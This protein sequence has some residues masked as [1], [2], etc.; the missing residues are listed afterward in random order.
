MHRNLV[1]AGD[2]ATAADNAWR[3]ATL[4][5][6][7]LR[8]RLD[9]G[10]LLAAPP[11]P[12][13]SPSPDN[14]PNLPAQIGALLCRFNA[15]LRAGLAGRNGDGAPLGEQEL[16]AAEAG[17]L[18]LDTLATGSLDWLTGR[19]AAAGAA[20]HQEMLL[21]HFWCGRALTRNL[22]R[23]QDL[24]D[25]LDLAPER[26]SALQQEAARLRQAGAS[27]RL[28]QLEVIQALILPALARRETPGFAWPRP[29]RPP[30]LPGLLER[31]LRYA[32]RASRQLARDLARLRRAYRQGLEHKQRLLGRLTVMA[33][34]LYAMSAVLLYAA[35]RQG[36]SGC[37]PLADLFCRQARRRVATWRRALYHNDDQ[38]AYD[39]ALDVLAGHYPWLEPFSSRRQVTSR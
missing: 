38:F 22:A 13:C 20:H 23:L 17:E 34:E 14:S 7:L 31:H 3:T 15:A 16:I 27:G 12:A 10:R 4:V 6:D 21:A 29:L 36:P 25:A 39:R 37:E 1:T 32:E 5:D 28:R 33:A 19:L 35:S 8:G 26:M 24:G 2:G 11:G 18:A 9:L 30:I